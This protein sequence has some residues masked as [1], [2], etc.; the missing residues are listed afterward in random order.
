ELA[1]VARVAP[2]RELLLQAPAEGLLG[3]VGA[4]DVELADPAVVEHDPAELVTDSVGGSHSLRFGL[5]TRLEEHPIVLVDRL[6]CFSREARHPVLREV[7]KGMRSE[8]SFL[9]T[10]TGAL[11]CLCIE[12]FAGLLDSGGAT[13]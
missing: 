3:F 1:G 8:E 10:A 2:V 5:Q 6:H 9:E 13:V 7:S 4:A 11:C 12:P